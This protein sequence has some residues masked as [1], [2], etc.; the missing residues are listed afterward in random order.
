[1]N[2]RLQNQFM[3]SQFSSAWTP[4]FFEFTGKL[5]KIQEN[6]PT[7]EI[8]ASRLGNAGSAT[9]LKVPYVHMAVKS[10]HGSK[11]CKQYFTPNKWMHY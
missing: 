7:P 9:G 5:S 1:M 10:E 6:E 4:S 11:K 8:G 2:V 3:S